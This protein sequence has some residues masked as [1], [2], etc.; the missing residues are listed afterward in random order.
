MIL[1]KVIIKNFRQYKD[2]TIDFA[3][4]KDKPFTII[5]GNNGTGKTTLLNALSWCLYGYEIHDYGDDS[6]MEI[7]NNKTENLA[8]DGESIE[9]SVEMKF[10]D[11]GKI[12]NFKRSKF[13]SKLNDEI[14]PSFYSDFVVEEEKDDGDVESYEDDTYII[15]KKLPKEIEEYFF[16]D[17][18]RLGDYFSSTSNSNIKNSVYKLSQLNL[19]DNLVDN[20]KKTRD[21]YNKE[22][23][24]INPQLGKSN[25]SINKIN[26]NITDSKNKLEKF[27]DDIKE[28]EMENEE[29]QQKLEGF[30]SIESKIKE[31]KQ[32]NNRIANLDKELDDLTSKKEKLVIKNYPYVMSYKYLKK[33]IDY[34]EDYRDKGYIPPDFKVSF[35]DD[36]LEEGKCICGLDLNNHEENRKHL[37]WVREQTNPVTNKSEVITVCLNDAK[38]IINNYSNIFDELKELNA[39]ILKYDEEKEEKLEKCK[40]IDN[41]IESSSEKEINEIKTSIDENNKSIKNYSERVGE[42]KRTIDYNNKQ[43]NKLKDKQSQIN[44]LNIKKDE[45]TKKY[46]FCKT[47]IYAAEDINNYLT[48][49]MRENIEKL[50]KDKFIK[51]QWKEEEFVDIRLDDEY[52]IFIKN[53]TGKEERPGD[54]SD[55]EK[56]CLGLCFMSALHNISGFDLPIIMDTPL[57]NLDKDMRH[58][59]AKFL[60]DFVEGKQTVLLVTGTEYT[61]DFRETLFKHVGKEYIIDWNNSDIGKESKVILND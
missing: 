25:E 53:K 57:G 33:F 1:D 26:E 32:L 7:C 48:S 37:E 3:K 45:Y 17:G 30:S 5:R 6:S 40:H 44:R 22:I 19:F 13:F 10:L 36:L 14:V 61:D 56:L 41:D 60:P 20:L 24:G 46:E 27:E 18:A 54:L 16:F 43:L 31:Y 15:D 34:G 8:E 29:C 35:L 55:G 11:D 4:D 52:N 23:K 58:N 50:T 9:V 38:N 59:I 42:L 28:L 39:K 12:L 21:K 2:V 49:E 51:I 47:A